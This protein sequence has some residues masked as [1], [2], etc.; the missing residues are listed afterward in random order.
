MACVC[1]CVFCSDSWWF[2]LSLSVSVC[3]GDQTAADDERRQAKSVTT[4]LGEREEEREEGE[5]KREE[6]EREKEMVAKDGER[7]ETKDEEKEKPKSPDQLQ[8]SHDESPVHE[9]NLSQESRDLQDRSH[10]LGGSEQSVE[11]VD[12]QDT[13]RDEL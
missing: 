11:G 10:D 6:R 4:E 3:A 1:V 2:C 5:I 9:Q 13:T 7:I 12:L 8:E